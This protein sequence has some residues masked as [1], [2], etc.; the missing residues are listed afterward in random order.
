MEIMSS[1]FFYFCFLVVLI[2]SGLL[3]RWVIGWINYPEVTKSELSPVNEKIS[4]VV[5]VRNEEIDILNC[6]DSL[7]QQTY[8]N[9]EIIIS[10]D[11]SE[12]KTR[13]LVHQFIKDNT[14]N[15]SVW[16]LLEGTPGSGTGKKSALERAI[17]MATGNLIVT[18]DADCTMGSCW[19][20]SIANCHHNT[21]AGMITGFVRLQPGPGWF[22]KFQALEFIS[23]SGTGAASVI[24]G[25]PLMCNGAN[26]A[27]EKSA[28][29][30]A[31]GY[32]YG[33][34]IPSGDDTFLMLRMAKS[35]KKKVVFNKNVEG[36]ITSR[37]AGSLNQL[38]AQRKR[39]AS[40]VQFYTEGYI[41]A[42]G[43]LLFA[44]NIIMLTTLLAGLLSYWSWMEVALI[45]SIKVAADLLFLYPLIRFAR[46]QQLLLLFLP[47]VI[48][49]PV[50]ALAGLLLSPGKVSYSW[51]G[52]DYT[53]SK[54][55]NE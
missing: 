36:T 39:W 13:H 26:L 37:P 32:S 17:Q 9:L 40:K 8:K 20:Q 54:K 15:K 6:L 31:G 38:I 19:I 55:R 25:H 52:R 53:L 30:E 24:I 5:A 48:I 2:Y 29:Y 50:Y 14:T 23:L 46:Q 10:D 16:I 49:Y 7:K 33:G 41:K 47:A 51:K 3:C 4:V 34:S 42:T 28:F 21:N 18:T 44:V 35:G 45:W 11:F 12:D 1:Y 27:F 22:G 43:A